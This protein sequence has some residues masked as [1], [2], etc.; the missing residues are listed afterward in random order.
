MSEYTLSNSAA[1]IDSAITRVVSADTEPTADS[2]N[3]VT[4]GGVKTA[5]D[6]LAS[7]STLTVGSFTPGALET[8]TD[9]LTETDNSIPTSAAVKD[10]VDT[11]SQSGT[12]NNR[13]RIKVMPSDFAW[14]TG[15]SGATSSGGYFV[16]TGVANYDLPEGFKATRVVMY[17]EYHH[18]VSVNVYEGNITT[19]TL[20]SKGSAGGQGSRTIDITDVTSTSTNYLSIN[21]GTAQQT[22]VY[23]GYITLVAV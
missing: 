8:S 5:I 17:I 3:M 13:L 10:F 7:S 11:A 18:N 12:P 23:G 6:E 15:S 19:S 21:V 14:L 1:V 9:G 20:I 4:S 16:G 22:Q 2:E